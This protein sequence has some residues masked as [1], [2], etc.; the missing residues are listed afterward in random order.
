MRW[1]LAVLALIFIAGG[2]EKVVVKTA[3]KTTRIRTADMQKR[4]FRRRIPLQGTV[5]PVEF[6]TIS[7][8]ISGTLELLKVDEGDRI[9]KGDVLFG[10]DRQVLKNQVIV[11]EDE[12]KVRQAALKSA[13]I[14]LNIANISL[15]Q[16]KRDYDR[17]KNLSRNS[18]ISQS[19]LESAETDYKKAEMAVN[20]AKADI[21]NAVSQLKQAQSN[22]AIARKNLNDSTT[23]APFDCVVFDKFVE[24]NEFVSAGQDIVKLE[25]HNALEVI[26]YISSVYYDQVIPGKTPVDFTARDGKV[27]SRS[28]ITYKAPGIDPESRTFKIKISVPA[29]TGF[30]SGMLCELDIIL[31]EREG[32]GIPEE[33]VLLRANGRI[34]AFTVNKD[35][36]AES[37]EIK[38]GITDSGFSE[39]LNAGE[40]TGRRFVIS[41]QTFIN[42]GALLV[43][44]EAEKK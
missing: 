6:A 28:V 37:V 20:N 13:E 4:I 3:E 11:K 29:N 24:E 27:I 42:N 41:G 18:A 15:E 21:S 31:T 19:S 32:Y 22:L 12:I 8:K 33:A 9:K 1:S 14:A 44:A 23:V 2:C 34:I 17:A 16:A 10:I 38:K 40:L 43:D 7:A 39:I 30:V 26:C 5:Q 25:N 36:R 35:M